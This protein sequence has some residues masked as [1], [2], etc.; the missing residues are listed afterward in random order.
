MIPESGRLWLSAVPTFLGLVLT[1]WAL[2]S[3]PTLIVFPTLMLS[4]LSIWISAVDACNKRIP[5]LAVI[6]VAC[7]GL[8][9]GAAQDPLEPISLTAAGIFA[10]TLFWAIGEVTFRR[11]GREYLGLGDAKLVGAA[12]C[13][14]G[15]L[16]LPSVVLIASLSGIVSYLLVRPDSGLP[17]GPSLCFGLLAVWTS[18]PILI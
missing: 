15:I 4:G 11:T 18:G 2:L 3:T 1:L 17:F 8:L 13:C 16:G 12:G 9:S 14:V 7:T 10:Y 5:N 6:A